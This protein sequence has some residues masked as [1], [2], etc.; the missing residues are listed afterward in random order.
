MQTIMLNKKDVKMGLVHFRILNR[1]LKNI[2][3]YTGV[4]Q[5]NFSINT[6]ITS[7]SPLQ[8]RYI[9]SVLLFTMYI[10]PLSYD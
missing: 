7:P 8:R 4:A 10:C 1:S 5:T 6:V 2:M 9:K 3:I